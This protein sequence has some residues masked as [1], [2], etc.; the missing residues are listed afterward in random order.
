MKYNKDLFIN[1]VKYLIS[2]DYE[3]EI[4]IKLKDESRV[5]III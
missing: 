5:F 4:T 2:Y 3:P 1:N